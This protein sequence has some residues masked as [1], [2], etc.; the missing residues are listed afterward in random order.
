MEEK[1]LIDGLANRIKG[2]MNV[3]NGHGTLTNARFIYSKHGLGK[4]LA[5][6]ALVN[7]TKGAYEFEIPILDIQSVSR[8]KHGLSSSILVLETRSGE[9][10]RF[11]VTKYEEWEIAFRRA[12]EQEPVACSKEDSASG[13]TGN[14]CPECGGKLAG[15]EKF[16]SNCGAK[17]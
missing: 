7:L 16:C 9:V 6:G 17:L 3:Q 5:M 1:V 8:G 2:A 4:I 14:F 12:M 11:A 15:T 10:Y 13:N